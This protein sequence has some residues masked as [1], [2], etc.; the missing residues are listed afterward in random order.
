M[1]E[2][3]FS[4]VN[5]LF[6][7]DYK[8]VRSAL[9]HISLTL[10]DGSLNA[11]IGPSGSGKTSLLSCLTGKLI[12]EGTITLGGM[13]LEKIKV[14]DR[15][16]SFVDQNVTLYPN[17]T[18]YENILFPLK[19]EKI[20]YEEADKK[21]KQI[22]Y[23]LDIS[24]LL[25]RKPKFLSLGQQ[26]RVSLAK[27]MAKESDIYLFDEPLASVDKPEREEILSLLKD[28]LLMHHK[29]S[30]YVTHQSEEAMKMGEE[31]F[32]LKEG[33]LLGEYTQKELLD[34]KDTTIQG[35]INLQDHEK[36]TQSR[37]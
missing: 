8:Q 12:Y 17:L 9:D 2:I 15:R 32:V 36:E 25:T 1:P 26:A 27:A 5:V 13:D 6:E 35:L 20:P 18:V 7:D 22:A 30:L 21:A 10:K 29:T 3:V 33:K 16:M 4:D 19:I 24:F 11:L 28:Y 23:D 31:I 34:S 37:G 14:K